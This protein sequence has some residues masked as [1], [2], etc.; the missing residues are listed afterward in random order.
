M[1][2]YIYIYIYRERD[3]EMYYSILP[4][5]RATGALRDGQLKGHAPKPTPTFGKQAH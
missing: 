5:S 4:P 2:L 1:Y 3:I